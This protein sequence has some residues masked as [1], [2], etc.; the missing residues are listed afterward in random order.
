MTRRISRPK[1]HPWLLALAVL[2]TLAI[3]PTARAADPRETAAARQFYAGKYEEALASYVDLAVSTRN[4]VYMCEIGRCH[5]RL[6]RTD[7]AVKNLR[8]CLAQAQLEP[9]KRR[10]FRA[11]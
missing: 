1:T 7:E 9:Q 4:P 10:E 2:V 6:G 3:A 11:L 5:Y 8:D